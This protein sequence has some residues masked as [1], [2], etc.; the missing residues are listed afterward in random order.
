MYA[1]YIQY[2]DGKNS[3]D[4]YV[5]YWES[6]YI[7]GVA[8]L[9]DSDSHRIMRFPSRK[10]AMSFGYRMKEHYGRYLR[11]FEVVSVY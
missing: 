4:G 9:H 8:D 6:G 3:R 10:A 1:L 7:P 2:A 5:T 11:Y